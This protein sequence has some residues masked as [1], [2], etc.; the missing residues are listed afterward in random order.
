MSSASPTP[1]RSGS[2]SAYRH[3]VEDSVYIAP[4]HVG[5]GVGKA[6]L[7][8]VIAACEA[9]ALR[10]MVALIGDSGNGASIG[11]HRA[12]GFHPAGTL[13]GVGY[14]AGR[15]L[16]VVLMQRPL[17]GGAEGPPDGE[18]LILAGG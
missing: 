10:Q 9:L 12:C 11:V 7:A 6:L 4:D 14:K 17:N 13:A 5:R 8:A 2:R 15:W 16:D 18:G 3:T 1:R